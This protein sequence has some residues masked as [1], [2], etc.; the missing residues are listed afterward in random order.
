ML[1]SWLQ[2]ATSDPASSLGLIWR[3]LSDY[4]FA[5]WRRYAVA[6]TLMGFGAGATALAAY[7]AGDV[8][9]QAYVDRNFQAV[10]QTSLLIMLVFVSRGAAVYGHSVILSRIGNSIVAENQRRLFDKLQ[11]QNLTYFSDRHSSELLARLS[12]GAGA[13]NSALNLVITAIGRDALTLMALT[14]VMFVQDP[15]MSLVAFV[16]APPVVFV[17]RKLVRRIRNVAMS[18]WHGGAQTFETLQ[19]T[20]QGIRLVKSFTLEEQMRARFRANV[21]RVQGDSNKMARVSNR[22]GPLVETLAGLA[23]AGLMVYAG[24]R[25]INSGASPGEFFSFMTAFL[26]AYEPAKRLARL[27]LDLNVALV[28]VRILFEIV[29]APATEPADDNRPSLKIASARLEFRDVTFSYRPGEPTIRTMSFVADPGRM[30]A[31]V[32]PSG[33]GKSTVLNLIL[34]FY[35]VDSGV[36]TIDSQDIASVSRRSLRSQISYVGQDVFLFRTTVRENIAFGRP[37]ASEADIIAAAKAAHA[38]DF[39]S[40]MPQGYDTLV[41]ERG[42]GLSGGER[43]RVAIARALI[44]DAPLI[45]LDEATA[46]LDSESEHHV[47]QALAEL[48]KGRTTLVIAH[49]LSTVMHADNIL[50][51]EAGQITDSGRHEELLRKGG[52]Y[53]LFYRLQLAHQESREPLA[54]SGS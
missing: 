31:L 6:F 7:L 25:V 19:E 41:G 45:L 53:A 46:A 38:H 26:L 17:L 34:R 2:S 8:I 15:V 51:I 16:I 35:E 27:N 20:V 29:D 44:K 1:K 22:T 37:G 52:R 40:A 3:L 4:G 9:N 21:A 47:Q 5:R 49:R 54:A 18:Q 33:G 11:Q 23:V 10:I 42:L 36:I 28:G 50:V 39:I 43:Q 30:T 32:G 14:V 12:T 13:A 48:C 24:H